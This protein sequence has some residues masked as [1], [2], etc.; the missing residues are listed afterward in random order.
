MHT[1]IPASYA[2]LV[3]QDLCGL[4]GRPSTVPG[5]AGKRPRY[6]MAG[7]PSLIGRRHGSLKPLRGMGVAEA[8]PPAATQKPP[9]GCTEAAATLRHA[10]VAQPLGAEA[11]GRGVLFPQLLGITRCVASLTRSTSSYSATCSLLRHLVKEGCPDA[12][13]GGALG[14]ALEHCSKPLKHP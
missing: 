13:M 2:T 1:W 10:N 9:V 7:T 3:R 8:A 14:K 4:R 5:H 11:R 6:G 12:T